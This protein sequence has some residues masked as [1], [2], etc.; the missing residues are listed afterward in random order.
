[1]LDKL[2]AIENRWKEVEKELINPNIMEDMKRYAALNKEYK[3]LKEIVDV[4]HVYRNV[5]DNIESAKAVLANEKDEEFREMA[6][7]ELDELSSTQNKMEEEIRMM[8]VPADPEDSKNAIVEIRGGTG[9]DEASIFAGDLYRMYA[10]FC[11]NKGWKM[12]LMDFTAGT[13]G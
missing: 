12:E 1:M 6:K 7:E 4:Y 3:D 9:G 10:R 11:D 5:M 13:A 2:E 8:L